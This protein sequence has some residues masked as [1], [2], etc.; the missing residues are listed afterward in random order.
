MQVEQTNMYNK[1][2]ETT[3]MCFQNPGFK[4]CYKKYVHNTKIIYIYDDRKIN[5]DGIEWTSW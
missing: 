5:M 4:L 1:K 3:I 2:K